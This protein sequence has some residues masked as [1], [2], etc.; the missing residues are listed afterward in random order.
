MRRQ[1]ID[2]DGDEKISLANVLD[3][4][5]VESS[6]SV[7]EI[8]IIRKGNRDRGKDHLQL[9]SHFS[10]PKN[11]ENSQ[12]SSAFYSQN[13][14]L[15]IPPKPG[16]TADEELK[17]YELS[18]QELPKAVDS[19]EIEES[20]LRDCCI[21]PIK[22]MMKPGTANSFSRNTALKQHQHDMKAFVISDEKMDGYQRAAIISKLDIE[23]KASFKDLEKAVAKRGYKCQPIDLVQ[24]LIV[25]HLK[26]PECL[27][28]L[29]KWEEELKKWKGDEVPVSSSIEYIREHPEWNSIGGLDSEGRR[30]YVIH[31]GSVIPNEILNS[32]PRYCKSVN[33]LWDSLTINVPEVQAGLCFIC[34]FQNFG[35]S[36][37]SVS[38]LLRVLGLMGDKYPLRLR[39]IYFLDQ[40]M[41]FLIISKIVMTFLP[42]WFKQRIKLT[43]REK[44]KEIIPEDSLPIR[45]GGNNKEAAD[46]SSWVVRR[47]EVRYGSS[48]RKQYDK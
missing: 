13:P 32:F 12:I 2:E 46:L 38:L 47:L 24:Y 30:V 7:Q 45:V 41:Y 27:T 16:A 8:T 15:V 31:F 23:E 22:I 21:T 6:P 29:Q 42:K 40:P 14:D 5:E 18:L 43:S 35:T 9:Q 20:T 11:T 44:L 17:N 36:N 19:S 3:N 34:D 4:Y 39:R 1:Y 26:I 48:W 28:R 37:W 33:V 10:Q 25:S